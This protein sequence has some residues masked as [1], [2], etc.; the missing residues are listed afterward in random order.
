[1]FQ[2]LKPKWIEWFR[3]LTTNDKT[4]AEKMSKNKLE[5]EKDI[6]EDR[7]KDLRIELSG[8]DQEIQMA[9]EEAYELQESLINGTEDFIAR[10]EKANEENDR[11]NNQILTI[12]NELLIIKKEKEDVEHQRARLEMEMDDVKIKGEAIKKTLD[13]MKKD[14]IINDHKLDLLVKEKELEM[15][16]KEREAKATEAEL[17]L[18]NMR[19]QIKNLQ[20]KEGADGQFNTTVFESIIDYNTQNYKERMTELK[21]QIDILKTENRH[22]RDRLDGMDVT[23]VNNFNRKDIKLETMF[24]LA[25][26]KRKIESLE[27]QL[28]DKTVEHDLLLNEAKDLKKLT[29]TQNI[30]I[31]Q[32]KRQLANA[33]LRIKEIEHLGDVSDII[34]SGVELDVQ[35][36]KMLKMLQ[37]KDSYY[38]DIIEDKNEEIGKLEKQLQEDSDKSRRIKNLEDEVFE[39][40][41]DVVHAEKKASIAKEFADRL[42]I[43]Q[44]NSGQESETKKYRDLVQKV[45][46][47]RQLEN[48]KN[49]ELDDLRADHAESKKKYKEAL[50]SLNKKDFEIEDLNDQIDRLDRAIRERDLNDDE[51]KEHRMINDIERNKFRQLEN[52]RE[53]LNELIRVQKKEIIDKETV[54]NTQKNELKALR[55]ESFNLKKMVND[56]SS[57][58][59]IL[60]IKLEEASKGLQRQTDAIGDLSSKNEK[61]REQIDLLMGSFEQSNKENESVKAQLAS[62]IETLEV[63]VKEKSDFIKEHIEA[64]KRDDVET[65]AILQEKNKELASIKEELSNAKE[66][67]ADTKKKHDELVKANE[68]QKQ[69]NEQL[70]KEMGLL[71]E[72]LNS[73]AEQIEENDTKKTEAFAKEKEQLEQRLTASEKK[74]KDLETKMVDL[75]EKMQEAEEKNQTQENH[76]KDLEQEIDD[77]ATAIQPRIDSLH[78]Q[79]QEL[80]EENKRLRKSAQ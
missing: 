74:S 63:V 27:K 46:E 52:E 70:K 24:E 18:I 16:I 41:R 13:A 69:V 35:N 37:E 73:I 48:D 65:E 38:K 51:E 3:Q 71:N 55:E 49:K 23:N 61:L 72:E 21:A 17:K 40:K 77:I 6:L 78:E 11:L 56:Y 59:N 62:E 60:N 1:M 45:E 31:I 29:H 34:N 80:T 14:E 43:D 4:N 5:V 22:L 67:G 79:I 12:Q 54:I 50:D 76:I 47:L 9:K 64:S 66:I 75:R 20:E 42:I 58:N 8:K 2:D 33:N 57:E 10:I 15:R 36:L 26:R 32:V 19:R 25:D 53:G 44:E 68:E 7:I 30:E 28:K 39:L